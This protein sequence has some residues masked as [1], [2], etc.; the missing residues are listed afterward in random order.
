MA[1]R[2]V[3]SVPDLTL[4]KRELS[5]NLINAMHSYLILDLQNHCIKRWTITLLND[6]KPYKAIQH[7][8]LVLILYVFMMENSKQPNIFSRPHKW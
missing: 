3:N 5:V 7:T 1:P 8:T 2:N 6:D 4:Y